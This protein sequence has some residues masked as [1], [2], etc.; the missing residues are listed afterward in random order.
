MWLMWL[1]VLMWQQSEA[2]LR[3]FGIPG[4]LWHGSRNVSIA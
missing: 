3:G 4:D 2:A 1:V